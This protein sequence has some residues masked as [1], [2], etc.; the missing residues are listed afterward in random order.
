MSRLIPGVL[1]A[2]HLFPVP[3]R[4]GSILAL[5]SSA[6]KPPL[7]QLPPSPR[8]VP[9]PLPPRD[10]ASE[11]GRRREAL[12]RPLL[13]LVKLPRGSFSM[14][15]GSGGLPGAQLGSAVLAEG[16]ASVLPPLGGRQ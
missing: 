1:P 9:R 10:G 15:A 5:P 14:G 6:A 12:P 13:W 11:G 3:L 7:C 8:G 16:T 4:A 2:A